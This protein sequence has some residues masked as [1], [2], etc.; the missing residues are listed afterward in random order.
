MQ[1]TNHT[2]STWNLVLFARKSLGDSRHSAIITPYYPKKMK[3][4][5]EEG[6]EFFSH[7]VAKSVG[8]LE[9]LVYVNAC[10]CYK[11]IKYM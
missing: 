6:L 2:I 10:Y 4:E 5:R 3:Y 7:Q 1:P 11:N 8:L 9:S